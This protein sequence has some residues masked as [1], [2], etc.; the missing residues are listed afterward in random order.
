[1]PD[2]LPPPIPAATLVLMRPV[3]QGGPPEILMIERS[4]LMAFAAGALVFPG[5]R[6][7]PD[8]HESAAAFAAGLDDGPARIAAIRETI[9]ESGIAAALHP[10]PDAD[11]ILSLRRGRAAGAPVA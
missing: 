3:P 6:I 7:E 10:P 1:M 8:D 11:G 2:E 9:E 5:G 4:R